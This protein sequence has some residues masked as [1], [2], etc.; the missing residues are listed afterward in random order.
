MRLHVKVI[1][2]SICSLVAIL[3]CSNKKTR[4]S[5]VISYRQRIEKKDACPVKTP[6]PIQKRVHVYDSDNAISS[7]NASESDD[8]L[9]RS[10]GKQSFTDLSWDDR[11]ISSVT[12]VNSFEELGSPLSNPC[13]IQSPGDHRV[14][15]PSPIK[16]D[17]KK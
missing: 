11:S 1:T 8:V 16:P 2:L 3:D 13:H 9:E 10:Y 6:S 4:K 5:V 12:S 14:S 15:T 17:P 7:G